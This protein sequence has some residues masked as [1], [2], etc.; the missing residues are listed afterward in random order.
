MIVGSPTLYFNFFD[1]FNYKGSRRLSSIGL[2]DKVLNP[3][4][5]PNS[6]TLNPLLRWHP[7][8]KPW[9]KV[10][11]SRVLTIKVG[12]LPRHDVLPLKGFGLRPE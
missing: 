7:L 11:G 6:S 9:C 1:G 4:L 8:G 10:Y 2:F 3:I 5:N 12:S